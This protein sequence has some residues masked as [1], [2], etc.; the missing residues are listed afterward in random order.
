MTYILH[1][2]KNLLSFVGNII[3]LNLIGMV[4]ISFLEGIGI[5]LL[6]PL[7][8]LTGLISFN[9]MGLP[10]NLKW[11]NEFLINLPLEISLIV[12]LSIFVTIMVSQGFFQR[13]QSILNGQ[14]QQSYLKN[15][16]ERTYIDFLQSNWS[17]FLKTRK[18]DIVTVMTTEILK[19]SN[20]ISLTL[21]FVAS[22]IFTII[23]VFFAFW[24]SPYMTICIL[25]F[26]FGM[27]FVSKK[28]I[29]N[30]SNIGEETVYLSKTYLAGITDHFNGIKD[31]KSNSIEYSYI[32]WLEKFGVRF[33]NNVNNLIKLRSSSQLLF[34]S[35]SAFLIAGMIY[36]SILMFKAQPA[37]VLLVIAI[38][39]RIW[40]RITSIQSHLEQ[41]GEI[42]PS[43]KNLYHLQQISQDA[44]EFNKS[45]YENSRP[46]VIKSGIECRD[47]SFK[48]NKD[49]EEYIL[50]GINMFIP[51]HG[52]TAIVGPSGAGKSTLVDL[53][54]G[55][56][57]P[58]EGKVL[59][60]NQVL[61]E[62]KILS[63]R[64]SIGYVPQDPFLF[65]TSIKENLLM[66]EPDA[67][68]KDIWEA[69]SFASADEFVRNLPHG[70][71]TIIGDRGIRLSGGER[72]RIVLAR[73]ILRKPSILVLD[74]ATSA[75]DSENERKIQAAIEKLK[76]KMT[77]IV[78]A[79]RLSTIKN[80]NQVIVLD[81]GR[82]IQTGEFNQLTLDRKGMFSQLL[83]KQLE[84]SI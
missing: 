56:N 64:K 84:A 16:R 36:V 40:P 28:F 76:G 67:S 47:I 12:V 3:Y 18:T 60:D 43:F 9:D 30:S 24:L 59:V 20:G 8:S 54:M 22:I 26:G 52:M 41:F 7:I 10:I 35:V 11:L 5:L 4:L 69:L 48:Y 53:I 14:I 31:I 66:I 72:Q 79:H 80:A 63:L 65:N 21:N 78:I 82:I 1:F 27:I 58:D 75:L 68:D 6:V 45:T 34:K 39:M 33:E 46:L 15:L 50:N 61:T 77:I 71:D 23:Q 13:Q 81:Q 29:R 44:K 62:D 49:E 51:S 2:I 32:N 37:Q 55:L 42:I 74:E 57:K 70:L 83:G 73:A 38:F 19:V 17:F 25:I